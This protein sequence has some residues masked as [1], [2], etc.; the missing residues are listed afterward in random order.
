MIHHAYDT[1]PFYMKREKLPLRWD[2]YCIEDILN[3][4]PILE[5]NEA[6]LKSGSLLSNHYLTELYQD[7][8]IM[9]HTSGSTGKYINVYW[10]KSDYQYSLFSLYQNRKRLS[11]ITPRSKFCYFYTARDFGKSDKM[12]ERNQY[13][14]GFCKSNLTEES[15]LQIYFEII[16]F[17]VEWML[18]QPSILILLCELREKYSLPAISTIRYIEVTGEMLFANVKKRIQK[19]FDAIIVNHYGCMEVNS[20]AFDRGDDMLR[21]SETV[22]IEIVDN[23]GTSVQNGV[24]GDICITTLDNHCMPWMRYRVGDRGI[25]HNVDGELYLEL[26]TGRIN[27][28]ILMAD[29]QKVNSYVFVRAID[30]TNACLQEAIYQFQVIQHDID[31]FEIR[32]VVD[33]EVDK[34]TVESLIK[35]N[36]AQAGLERAN[37]LF[38]FCEGLTPDD[39][40]G[41]M[42]YFI[43][44]LNV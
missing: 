41:K 8:L 11:G 36:I 39:E 29:G 9:L 26:T 20:I 6:V 12:M 7:K 33:E 3:L 44:K 21:I 25:L 17:G 31:K 24:E 4:I 22:W 2:E 37:Y 13:K 15:L 10:N 43:T 38:V 35:D 18:I 19:N 30:N 40:K 16:E 23:N 27:D 34:H 5:K 1:V 32:L 14:I 42:K 28:Y